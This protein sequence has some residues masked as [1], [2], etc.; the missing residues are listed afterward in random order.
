MGSWEEI[1]TLQ[2][3]FVTTINENSIC[4]SRAIAIDQRGSNCEV[5]KEALA[6]IKT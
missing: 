5:A 2:C 1:V 3:S 6:W 4:K